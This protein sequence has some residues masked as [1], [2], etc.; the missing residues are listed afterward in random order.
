MPPFL[1]IYRKHVLTSVCNFW[2][3]ICYPHQHGF[4][5]WLEYPKYWFPSNLIAFSHGSKLDKRCFGFVEATCPHGC[6]YF[7]SIYCPS[8]SSACSISSSSNSKRVSF[9]FF[10]FTALDLLELILRS[11]L[12]VQLVYNQSSF[13]YPTKPLGGCL[14][15]SEMHE[16]YVHHEGSRPAANRR[17]GTH[18]RGAGGLPGDNQSFKV[19]SVNDPN[20]K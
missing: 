20:K 2:G 7:L 6:L 4:S 18:L 14:Q 1:R 13:R 3:N 12:Q 17:P 5:V 19:L 9:P 11:L 15:A 10:N 8:D 16:Q